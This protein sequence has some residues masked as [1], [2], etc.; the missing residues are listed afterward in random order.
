MKERGK[1]QGGIWS[2]CLLDF[3]FS[4]RLT[5]LVSEINV[6]GQRATRRQPL[7]FTAGWLS[8]DVEADRLPGIV[9]LQLYI[10]GRRVKMTCINT[11]YDR[12][13]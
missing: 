5:L 7:T 4:S 2:S 3:F 10:W 8:G 11:A 13:H 9:T 12:V 6:F 1:A